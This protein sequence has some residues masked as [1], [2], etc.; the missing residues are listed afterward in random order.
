MKVCGI[1]GE[2][3]T[4]LLI[5]HPEKHL[6]YGE[7][8]VTICSRCH[9][10]LHKG[11]VEKRMK[12]RIIIRP[13][14]EEHRFLQKLKEDVG[15]SSLSEVIGLLIRRAKLEKTIS[16]GGL[17]GWDLLVLLYRWRRKGELEKML[18]VM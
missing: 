11:L 5:D 6:D 17:T 7:G 1:C 9:M 14:K 8:I 12:P 15:A 10:K 3:G 16:E 4:R 2:R 13:S 18:S